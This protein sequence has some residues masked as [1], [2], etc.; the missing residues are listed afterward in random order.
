MSEQEIASANVSSAP[1]GASNIPGM[2]RVGSIPA[3]TASSATNSPK[4]T[5]TLMGDLVGSVLGKV[6][7]ILN[8]ALIE[9][10]LAAS[11]SAGHY[12]VLAGGALTVVYA[13][14]GAIKFNS[15]AIFAVGP[16]FVVALAVAQF[17]AIRFLS[18]SDTVIASTPSRM[19]SSAF[20]DCVGLLV[21]LFAVTTLLGGIA[22]SIA[23]KS[24]VP[25]LPAALSTIFLTC[26]GAVAL[27]P[28]MVNVT[29]GEGT[30]GEEAIGV[31]SF[32]FKT[33]LKLVPLMFLLLAVAGTLTIAMS[34][35]GEGGAFASMAQGIVNLFPLPIQVPYG[36]TGTA[37]VLVACLVPILTYFLFLLQ[38]LVVDVLRAVLAVPAKLDAL[39]R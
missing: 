21:L 15:F 11:K 9:S 31:L 22:T 1:A 3:A 10:A 32:F 7:R 30:A 37:L 35:F 29:N 18:A 19:S 38:Y 34:F 26:F 16:G 13:I 20:L 23:G 2:A 6:T 4:S 28:R 24:F 17:A 8:P 36:L 33:A 39:R 12:A 25:L 27:H 5:P 14:Y